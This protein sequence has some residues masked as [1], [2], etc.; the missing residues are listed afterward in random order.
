MCLFQTERPD[1]RRFLRV[2]EQRLS[3]FWTSRARRLKPGPPRWKRCPRSLESRPPREVSLFWRTFFLLSLLLLGCYPGLAAD[4]QGAGIRP[5]LAAERAPV[6]FDGQPQPRRAGELG[7]HRPR[8]AGQ[9]PGR[10][11]RRAH[12][13]ARTR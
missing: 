13:T 9:D 5:A 1:E 11:R 12:R 3:D 4:F 8:L 10:R 7:L 2:W 6:G